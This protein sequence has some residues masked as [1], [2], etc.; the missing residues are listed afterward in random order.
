MEACSNYKKV[1]FAPH[2][3]PRQTH[4]HK[5]HPHTCV[6]CACHMFSGCLRVPPLPTMLRIPLPASIQLSTGPWD[7]G[8]EYRGCR[9]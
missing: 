8:Q 4:S 7:W 6:S 1:R 5:D 3:R 9:E 2:P